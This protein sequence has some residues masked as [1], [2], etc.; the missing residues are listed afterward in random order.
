MYT[1]RQISASVAGAHLPM[2]RVG[3]SYLALT[4]ALDTDETPEAMAA[5]S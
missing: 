5:G 1:N 4:E 3:L 2:V